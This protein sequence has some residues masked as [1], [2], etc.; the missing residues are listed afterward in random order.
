MVMTRQGLQANTTLPWCEAVGEH[1]DKLKYSKILKK[2]ETQNVEPQI[3]HILIA[4]LSMY[5]AK[6][7][8]I[9]VMHNAILLKWSST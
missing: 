1:N 6:E 8:M 5:S 7:S 3:E 9:Q 4:S 2:C